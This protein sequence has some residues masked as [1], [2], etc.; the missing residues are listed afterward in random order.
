ML[1]DADD[2]TL[3]QALRDADPLR[4][5]TPDDHTR[6][7]L[8]R[9]WRRARE[10]PVD[11]GTPRRR[12]IG[13]GGTG[14]QPVAAA[15][16]A[17]V[18]LAGG[19][20]VSNVVAQRDDGTG[21]ATQLDGD[22]SGAGAHEAA[23]DRPDA[24]PVDGSYRA[25][26]RH[27]DDPADTY[28]VAGG[29]ALLRAGTP[30]ESFPLTGWRGFGPSTSVHVDEQLLVDDETYLRLRVDEQT[31]SRWHRYTGS[32]APWPPGLAGTPPPVFHDGTRGFD[33]VDDD[34]AEAQGLTRYTA[35]A[36]AADLDFLGWFAPGFGSSEPTATTV[37]VWVDA[38]GRVRRLKKVTR[39]E[40]DWP[41]VTRFDRFD[42]VDPIDPPDAAGDELPVVEDVAGMILNACGDP[43]FDDELVERV[44]A[45]LTDDAGVDEFEILDGPAVEQGA[46]APPYLEDQLFVVALRFTDD[47]EAD[48]M[49]IEE[50][51]QQFAS[52]TAGDVPETQSADR[53]GYATICGNEL[54][55]WVGIDG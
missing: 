38:D 9:T 36:D 29:R 32:Q 13:A 40:P 1:H 46:A 2:A 45:E 19:V 50:K 16:M 52:V 37:D 8:E 48:V 47:I 53:Q 10:W 41:S 39:T 12:T 5:S 17:V 14:L 42:A 3:M 20:L 23:G 15:I 51:A 34:E 54:L 30:Q 33:R 35:D 28:L 21:A 49:A 25:V 18:L 22:P 27:G 6:H 44:T 31:R 26:Q 24:G 4:G 55:Q 11:D 7:R 43:A